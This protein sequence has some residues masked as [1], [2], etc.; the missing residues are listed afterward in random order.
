MFLGIDKDRKR[1]WKRELSS[2]TERQIGVIERY[3]ERETQGKRDREIHIHREI[4][5]ENRNRDREANRSYKK[6]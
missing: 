4:E 3:R 5:I 1:E 2:Y 6:M